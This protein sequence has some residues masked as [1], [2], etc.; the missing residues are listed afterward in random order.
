MPQRHDAT[1]TL[2]PGDQR[3]RAGDARGEA[4]RLGAID[5]RAAARGPRE[6]DGQGTAAVIIKY[7]IMHEA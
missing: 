1:K 2:P 3:A 5:A 7:Y 4:L 6:G